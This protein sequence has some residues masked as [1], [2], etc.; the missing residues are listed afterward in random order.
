MSLSSYRFD[1]QWTNLPLADLQSEA[2]K[3]N[4][5][6]SLQDLPPVT[7]RKSKSST[8]PWPGLSA[9]HPSCPSLKSFAWYYSASPS[10]RKILKRKH[11]QEVGISLSLAHDV[12]QP[13]ATAGLIKNYHDKRELITYQGAS[14]CFN[15]QNS[16]PRAIFSRELLYLADVP[17]EWNNHFLWFKWGRLCCFAET[18]WKYS[19]TYP[20]LRETVNRCRPKGSSVHLS[21]SLSFLF[22]FLVIAMFSVWAFLSLFVSGNHHILKR[23]S[24]AGGRI[25][26]I[27]SLLEWKMQLGWQWKFLEQRNNCIITVGKNRHNLCGPKSG[28][29]QGKNTME[30]YSI[31]TRLRASSG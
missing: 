21:H 13:D 27:F 6:H 12:I 20:M 23:A 29:F 16:P 26:E 11:S 25:W 14:C 24:G 4:T 8:D 30:S 1:G 3:V 19:L 7:F 2:K 28:V 22:F 5:I 31:I 18:V 10:E 15:I 9:C 17:N